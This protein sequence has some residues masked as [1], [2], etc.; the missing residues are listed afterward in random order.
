MQHEF[1]D[2]GERHHF[3]AD[4]SSAEMFGFC[5]GA[6]GQV[7]QVVIGNDFMQPLITLRKH[8]RH[9]ISRT[10][11]LTLADTPHDNITHASIVPKHISNLEYHAISYLESRM[12]RCRYLLRLSQTDEFLQTS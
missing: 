6:T 4:K 9:Q 10:L 1:N 2:T 8:I 7:S 3:F 11:Q 5:T 12:N